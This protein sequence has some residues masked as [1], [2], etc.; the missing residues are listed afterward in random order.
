MS[1]ISLLLYV[2]AIYLRPQEWIPAVYE[3]PLIY[4]LTITSVI[5]AFFESMGQRKLHLKEPPNL[6]MLGFLACMIMSHVAHTYLQG[7]IDSFSFFA[8]NVFLFFLFVNILVTEKRIKIMIWFI[9]IIT[10]I[11]AIEGIQ[12]HY[13]GIGWAGQTPFLDLGS[14][15]TRIRWIGIFNDPNDLALIFVVSAGFLISFIFGSTNLFVKILS[16]GMLFI[17]GQALFYTNSRGGFL[18]MAATISFFVL[19]KMKNKVLAL[20]VGVSIALIVIMFGPSRMSQVSSS[21]ASAYGRIEAWYQGFQMLK[22][23]PIF[24]VGDR[25][26]IE[27]HFRAAHNSYISVA[28]ELGLVGIFIWISL[29]YSCLK[30][31]I[32]SSRKLSASKPYMIGLE[33]GLVGFLSA[34]FFLSRSHVAV[35]YLLLALAA[36]FMY[37][38]LNKEE[39]EFTKKDTKITALLTIGILV[40]VWISM[41]FAI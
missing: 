20:I 3:W 22:S 9:I 30:G 38:I 29:I 41:K 40:I 18:A 2:I 36:S 21:E 39:Y 28:A 25:M 7:A 13:S 34:S 5:F 17:L 6:L 4:I 27:N 15:L 14:G 19:K 31:L 33:S 23:A 24:G 1:F 10:F 12:Q 37:T 35:L 16:C 32:L 8:P 26:F 11:L